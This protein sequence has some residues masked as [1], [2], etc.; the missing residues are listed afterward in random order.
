MEIKIVY[1][2]LIF[3][4]LSIAVADVFWL[5]RVRIVALLLLGFVADVACCM[6]LVACC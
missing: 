4:G 5:Q 1:F 6:L 2:Y 3:F